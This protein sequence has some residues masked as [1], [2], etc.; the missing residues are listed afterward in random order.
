MVD[1][2]SILTIAAVGLGLLFVGLAIGSAISRINRLAFAGIAL[3]VGSLLWLGVIIFSSSLSSYYYFTSYVY[4]YQQ[5]APGLYLFG[6]PDLSVVLGLIGLLEIGIASGYG[7]GRFV[8][9][10]QIA[11]T[12]L[13][14]RLP[15]PY[16]QPALATGE[17]N[18]GRDFAILMGQFDGLNQNTTLDPDERTIVQM[19]FFGGVSEIK[20][21]LDGREPEGYRYEQLVSLEW[22]T[23]K[24]VAVLTSLAKMK[25]L[26]PHP[27]E[28]IL[29]CK[30]CGATGLEYRAVCPECGSLALSK[31]KV[32]EHFSCG[33]IE[34]ESAFRNPEGDLIC[35]KCNKKLELIG[36][37]YRSLG[38]MY[39][40][41][42]CGAL[43]KELNSRLKCKKCGFTASP[44]DEKEEIVFG[45]SVDQ[46]TLSRIRQLVKPIE[47]VVE[48]YNSM[49][50]VVHAP[51]FVRGRSGI[52]HTFDLA[53]RKLTEGNPQVIGKD[54]LIEILASNKPVELE[55][56]TKEYGKISDV[57]YST[58]VL[59]VPYLTER[60]R[61]YAAAYRM[62]V[63]EGKNI[64]EVLMNADKVICPSEI[65]SS[66]AAFTR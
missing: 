62:T 10:R 44:D 24:E 51:S 39:V 35:S 41:Q 40:C 14:A 60:A 32:L 49:Q 17:T 6:N 48:H 52:E 66:K 25:L 26:N 27:A 55:D 36:N 22:S 63:Y 18:E 4:L 37:D 11:Q 1:V 20:P 54:Y 30:N 58:I 34:K 53:V 5:L 3:L 21:K 65:Q 47:T 46:N 59:V 56:I 29:H 15:I 61:N 64:E 28:K 23:R 16:I 19:L 12:K 45:F 43:S 33:M 57:D 13:A 31:N 9:K 38:L 2:I 8:R 7:L 42:N 50:Y